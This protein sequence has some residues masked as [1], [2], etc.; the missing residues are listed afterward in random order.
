MLSVSSPHCRVS[1]VLVYKAVSFVFSF[2]LLACRYLATLRTS[3]S[4]SIKM[5]ILGRLCRGIPEGQPQSAL[6]RGHLRVCFWSGLDNPIFRL[7]PGEE[8]T[9]LLAQYLDY[10]LW[11]SSS[12]LI[13]GE[14]EE[15]KITTSRGAA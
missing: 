6:E 10:D 12:S 3:Y 9:C 7:M 8:N 14:V 13:V 1:F 5:A 2:G 4:P 11:L 15:D